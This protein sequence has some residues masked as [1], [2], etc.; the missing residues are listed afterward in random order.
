MNKES[1][2]TA[3]AIVY[4][5]VVLAL[6]VGVPTLRCAANDWDWRCVFS[7]CRRIVP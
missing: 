3:K 6:L 2:D 4:M 5:L 1:R 7:E